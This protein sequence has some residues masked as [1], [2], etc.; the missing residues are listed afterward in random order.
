MKLICS[1]SDLSTHLSLASRAVPSRPERIV[2]GN[3]LLVAEKETQTVSLT[4][5]DGNLAIYTNFNAEVVEGGKIT[6]PA[7]LFNDIVSRLPEME[8]ILS[9]AEYQT[10]E[11]SILATLSSASGKF[12]LKGIDASEFPELPEIETAETIESTSISF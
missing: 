2:L 5:F 10:E 6:L 9:S 8:I 3:L 7:K 12:Q 11:E 1:Q 4:G